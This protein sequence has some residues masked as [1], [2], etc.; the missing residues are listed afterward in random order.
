MGEIQTCACGHD[1]ATHGRRGYGSC[2]VRDLTEHGRGVLE[3]MAATT[4]DRQIL[5]RLVEVVLALPGTAK[6]CG[7][8]R[9]RKGAGSR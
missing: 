2:R 6:D 7:C 9:F 4:K 3:E 8:K 1:V 5:A